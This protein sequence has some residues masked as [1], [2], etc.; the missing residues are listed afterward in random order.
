VKR[1][2]AGWR[3][4]YVAGDKPHKCVFCEK[5]QADDDAANRVLCRGDRTALVLNL[6]PYTNGHLLVVPYVH[7]G[8]LVDLDEETLAEMMRMA[9]KGVRLIRTAMSPDGFNVGLNLGRAAGAG[10]EDHVHIHIVPRWQGD[11]NFMPVLGDVRVIPEWLDDTYQKLLAALGEMA[12]E[13]Q[14]N[15]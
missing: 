9:A 14:N 2:W 1:I 3:M 8:D 4:K 6:Y 12:G 7:V 11:T 15:R 5:V 13:P 10:I